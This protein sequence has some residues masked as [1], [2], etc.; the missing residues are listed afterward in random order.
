MSESPSAF[1][2]VFEKVAA[3]FVCE[4]VEPAHVSVFKHVVYEVSGAED[5]GGGRHHDTWTHEHMNMDVERVS[6][7]MNMSWM[8][9]ECTQEGTTT[10]TASVCCVGSTGRDA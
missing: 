1:N 8:P 3:G 7:H 4:T 5:C 9:H 2:G 10:W 6:G